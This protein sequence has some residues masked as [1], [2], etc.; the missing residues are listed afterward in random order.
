M[1]DRSE[2]YFTKTNDLSGKLK[3]LAEI[4]TDVF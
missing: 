2:T 3:E 4:D 1:N